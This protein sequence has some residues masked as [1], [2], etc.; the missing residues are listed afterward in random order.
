MTTPLG[1]GFHA[2][3]TLDPATRIVSK[4]IQHG[5]AGGPA[6]A[7][8]TEFTRLQRFSMALTAMPFLRCPDPLDVD[9]PH[10]TLRMSHCPGEPLQT[11]LLT[12]GPEVEA[13]LEHIAEQVTLGLLRYVAEFNEP[14]PDLTIANVLYESAQRTV[15]LVD[16]TPVPVAAYDAARTPLEVSLG[17]LV[18][19]GTYETVRPANCWRRRYH[20]RVQALQVAVVR[21]V[22]EQHQLHSEVIQ[23]VADDRFRIL[24]SFG[25]PAR[26]LWYAA[27]AEAFR[28]RAG[29]VVAHA[30]RDARRGAA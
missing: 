10:G 8:L 1:R 26:G 22:A 3:V 28:R 29:R 14:Y 30:L 23:R 2:T 11:L 4:R 12:G 19:V 18:A 27:A 6:A 13:D 15:T 9:P 24:R 21:R 20:R 5:I 16:L 7:A 25:G 17:F